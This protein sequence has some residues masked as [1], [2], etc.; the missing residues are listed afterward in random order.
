MIRRSR[1]TEQ[2]LGWAGEWGL[3]ANIM[4]HTIMQTPALNQAEQHPQR[5]IW[6]ELEKSRL[7]AEATQPSALYQAESHHNTEKWAGLVELRLQAITTAQPGLTSSWMPVSVLGF[8]PILRS[9]HTI[10]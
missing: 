4:K 6:A 9:V 7:Q 8:R 1:F 10:M 3:Q 2:D 5:E